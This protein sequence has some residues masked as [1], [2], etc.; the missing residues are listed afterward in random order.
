MLNLG[1][2]YP[3]KREGLRP[4]TPEESEAL[5]AKLVASLAAKGY[6]ARFRTFV[7]GKLTNH[8]DFKINVILKPK[9]LDAAH[10]EQIRRAWKARRDANRL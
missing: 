6:K 10:Y 3:H 5:G 7:H 9:D 8:N 4:L 2:N 1:A